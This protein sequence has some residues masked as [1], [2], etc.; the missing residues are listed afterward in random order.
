MLM[1]SLASA[2][3]VKFEVDAASRKQDY[4]PGDVI[5]INIVGD[6]WANNFR[7]SAITSNNGGR[8]LGG[9]LNPVFYVNVDYGTIVNGG[10]PYVLISNIQGGNRALSGNPPPYYY[11]FNFQIPDTTVPLQLT[12]DDYGQTYIANMGFW[13]AR[14]ITSLRLNITPEPSTLLLFGLVGLILRK[15]LGT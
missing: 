6:A 14:N 7:V 13:E 8:G 9:F 11:F 2:A 3:T 4:A 1:T 15:K 5:R 10:S 12:I